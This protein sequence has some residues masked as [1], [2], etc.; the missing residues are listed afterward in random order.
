AGEEA[1]GG[2]LLGRELVLR[3][4]PYRFGLQETPAFVHPA[5]Q[6][7]PSERQIVIDG[8]DEAA[9]AGGENGRGGVCA[10]GPVLVHARLRATLRIG[11]DPAAGEAIELA[12]RDEEGR[13]AHAE[14][15]DD[16]LVHERLE[17]LARS[18][19]Y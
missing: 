14:R 1:R 4:L 15:L 16:A 6:E 2:L 7:H 10:G 9:G 5:L 11:E 12:L 19:A 17:R 13:V 18:A 3:H 8:R